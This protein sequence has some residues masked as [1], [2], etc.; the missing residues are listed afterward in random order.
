MQ[1]QLLQSNL[2]PEQ[3]YAEQLAPRPEGAGVKA[4]ERKAQ[5]KLQEQLIETRAKAGRVKELLD[6]FLAS[7]D[8]DLQAFHK[9]AKDGYEKAERETAAIEEEH[10]IHQQKL[11]RDVKW[12]ET[13]ESIQ[14]RRIFAARLLDD[15][16]ARLIEVD[17]RMRTAVHQAIAARLN[18]I[19]EAQRA[20]HAEFIEK[21]KEAGRDRSTLQ[22]LKQQI[23][24]NL[25]IE[26]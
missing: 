15:A 24:R 3:L 8:K 14:R 23:T 9:K 5:I 10:W 4:L 1:Q 11:P 25:F 12:M 7:A 17:E 20:I 22:M 26:K 21:R 16:K 6:E 2:T 18:E 19:D 13:D